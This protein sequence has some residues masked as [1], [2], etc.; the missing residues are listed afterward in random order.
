MTKSPKT[1]AVKHGQTASSAERGLALLIVLWIIASAALVVSSFNAT[2][3]SGASFVASEVQLTKTDALLNA[4]VEIAATRLIDEEETRRWLP[5]DK[6]HSV[7]FSEAELTVVISDPNGL[8]DLN[9]A[10]KDLLLG[11]FKKFTASDSDAGRLRDLILRARGEAP[12]EEQKKKGVHRNLRDIVKKPKEN[13]SQLM[14]FVDIAQLRSLE[15]MT[16]ELYNQVAPFITIYSRDGRI[17]PRSAPNKVLSSIPKLT[18]TDI[19]RLQAVRKG[20][21][22]E[23]TTLSEIKR[24]AGAYLSDEPGPAYVVSV[25]VRRPGGKYPGRGVFIIATGL[26]DSAPYRLISKRPSSGLH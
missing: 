26:D 23:D 6:P 9:K 3:R 8:I 16:F 5:D 24:R 14:A 10:D 13:S 20:G 11:F 19:A 17:N 2:V 25:E 12:N 1:S 21:L 18:R 7:T 15:G 22:D 4:G